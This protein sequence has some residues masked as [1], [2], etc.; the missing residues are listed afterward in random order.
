MKIDNPQRPIA[1]HSFGYANIAQPPPEIRGEEYGVS[2]AISATKINSNI[3]SKIEGLF[4]I[5]TTNINIGSNN[6]V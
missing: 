5:H 2:A 6:I 3:Q 1:P 4:R